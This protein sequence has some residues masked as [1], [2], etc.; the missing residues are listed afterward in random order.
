ME[1]LFVLALVGAAWLYWKKNAPRSIRPTPRPSFQRTASADVPADTR[2]QV[3]LK[4]D[5]D[6]GSAVIGS[7]LPFP[8]TL[9]GIGEDEAREL[10]KAIEAN[11]WQAPGWLTLL[12]AKKNIRCKEI[13]EWVG[14]HRPKLRATIDA[15]IAASSEWASASELDREDILE[16]IKVSALEEMPIRPADIDTARTL[17]EDEPQDSSVDDALLE[18]FKGD[19]RLYNMLMYMMGNP[20]KV[21][22]APAASPDRKDLEALVT[23]GFVRQGSDIPVSDI[24]P[25]LRLVDMQ[26]IAGDAVTAKFT[27]KAKAIE[28]LSGLPDLQTRMSKVIS[29]RELFQ[30]KPVRDNYAKEVAAS[31]RYSAAVANTVWHTLRNGYSTA[32]TVVT[33]K[34]CEAEEWRLESEDCCP[35]CKKM[36]EKSWKRPPKQLPPFHIGCDASI[37]WS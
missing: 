11:G 35:T 20:S 26:E 10:A 2:E 25:T 1:V 14:S 28:V 32:Q 18:R 4:F 23:Q 12:V 30:L 13:D 21:W 15:K 6:N 34:E 8:I 19:V 7:K 22:I 24:L 9:V 16:E 31:Y 36:H 37:D 29:F 5:R 33:G 17:L 27:R 3:D